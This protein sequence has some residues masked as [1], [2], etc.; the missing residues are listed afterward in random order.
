MARIYVTGHRNPDTDSDRLRDR[1]RGARGGS[2]R[3]T[4]TCPVRLGELNEQTRWVLE[5][6]GA[7][8]PELLPHI[9]LRVCDVMRTRF[10]LADHREPVRGVGL[11]MAREEV[12]LVP[13]WT[14]TARSPARS[15][16]ARSPAGTSASRA[17]RLG[18]TRPPR[19]A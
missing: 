5:R 1:L 10:P 14:A 2:T 7:A 19:S 11:I 8:E 18:S 12:D 16:S 4:S 15:P 6:S 9:M 17:R 3:A 13:S